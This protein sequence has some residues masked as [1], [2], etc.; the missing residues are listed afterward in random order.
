MWL[1]ENKKFRPKKINISHFLSTFW[2]KSEFS[3]DFYI[4]EVT[5]LCHEDSVCKT[6]SSDKVHT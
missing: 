1:V 5:S 6:L 4:T 2:I 3:G